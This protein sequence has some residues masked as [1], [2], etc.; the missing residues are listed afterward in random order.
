MR[1]LTRTPK[2]KLVEMPLQ[3]IDATTGG[4]EK[5][6]LIRSHVMRG[7]NVGKTHPSRKRLEQKD[8]AADYPIRETDKPGV[9]GALLPR[10][11]VH[12][13]KRLLGLKHLLWNDL[14]RISFP[15]KLDS[16]SRN[17][18]RQCESRFS[19]CL[20]VRITESLGLT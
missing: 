20:R 18:V 10:R 12:H 3:F 16:S 1:S 19:L 8:A 6:R 11:M 17:L 14:S 13:D 5:R 4:R 7:K 15:N 2:T 9:S